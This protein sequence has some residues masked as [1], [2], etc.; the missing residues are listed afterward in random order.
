MDNTPLLQYVDCI[1]L[2][3]PDIETGLHF[4]RDKLGHKLL[5]RMA[6]A[7]G[8]QMKD[9][10]TEIVIHTESHVPDY[11]IK[12]Q[13]VDDAAR[14][15]EEA[16]G[17]IIKPPFDIRIGRWA[18]VQDPW[19]NQFSVLDFS[20]GLLVTDSEGNVVADNR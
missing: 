10:Q 6:D 2:S 5:W 12:V 11:A 9:T 7:A 16:G 20:K 17:K 15:V 4:Y 3:V 8:L 1:R 13:N 19:G 14:Q 18:V